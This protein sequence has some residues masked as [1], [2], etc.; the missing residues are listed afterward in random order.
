[1][2]VIAG[3]GTGKTTVLEH[4]IA[5]LISH[6]HAAPDEILA[7]TYTENAARNLHE[8]VATLLAREGIASA[9]F[10]AST[11]HAYCYGLLRKHGKAFQVVGREDLWVYLRRNIAELPLERFVKAANPG[12]FLDDLLSFYD[13]CR[14]ELVRAADYQA[15]VQRLRT[16]DLPLPRVGR[17]REFEE[18][19]R[20]EVIAYCE[21]IARVY[22]KVEEILA[23][24]NMG[25]WGDM[26][27]GALEV[28]T[29]NPAVLEQER[30]HAR[31]ILIDEF[32]DSNVAQIELAALLAEPGHNVFAV[33]D[34]DQ[35]IYR[36]RGATSGAFDEFA[37]RFPTLRRERLERNHRSSS[38]I[39][40]G[41]FAVIAKN[42]E[43]AGF[44]RAALR[45][46]RE[47][48]VVTQG[49][50]LEASPVAIVLASDPCAEAAEIAEAIRERH[51]HADGSRD[52]LRWREFAVLYRTH[53]HREQLTEEFSRRD[54]PFTV[55]GL[56]VLETRAI[57]DLLAAL[58]AVV[59]TRDAISLFRVAA[60]PQ[61]GI[62]PKALHHEMQKTGRETDLVAALEKLKEGRVVLDSIKSCRAWLAKSAGASDAILKVIEVFGL[63]VP[64]E[65][66][67]VL[68]NFVDAWEKKP[69]TESGSLSEF[70][71]YLDL[72]KE[73]RGTIP[74]QEPDDRLDAVRLLTAHAAKGLEWKQVHVI[75]LNAGSFP[76]HYQ[77]EVFAFPD[78]LRRSPHGAAETD[79]KLHMEEE[80]R[81]L[82]VAM[83]R[84]A[85]RLFLYARPGRG[86][87]K[88]PEGFLRELLR[89]KSVAPMIE[90]RGAQPYLTPEEEDVP[91]SSISA[92]LELP[93][94]RDLSGEPLSATAIENYNFCPLRFKIE[95][96]WRLPAEAHAAMQF[97]NVMH[98]VLKFYFDEV[99]SRGTCDIPEVL[100]RFCELMSRM[101][102]EDPLQRHLYVK[103][104]TVQLKKFIEAHRSGPPLLVAHTER[105]FKVEIGGVEVIGRMDRLD[106]LDSGPNR[107][108]IT[109]YKTGRPREQRDADQSLQLSI[110]AIAA[111]R[112]WSFQ[113]ERLV[114]HN[115][116]NNSRIE[117][118]RSADQLRA[119][120]EQVREVA[121]N[122]AAG[123]FDPN[124]GFHC[125][126][127]AYFSLCPETEQRLYSI[128]KSLQDVP[129]GAD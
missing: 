85:D 114:F 64:G 88:T 93:A 5:R 117:T 66:L 123:K 45:S 121:R 80:R 14:D 125:R 68:R 75:R 115:L 46:A 59:F 76:L 92:W 2:L 41:S 104:G 25:T 49:K 54:I 4:R 7:V 1:M 53:M 42:P 112:A 127:C 57:R 119:H 9:G 13:R 38:P 62:S 8:R 60:L 126:S 84:A 78:A 87:D 74:L 27:L 128:Q 109:D 37:R 94:Q 48:E 89:D 16:S 56:D 70:L 55:T 79:R 124:P 101:P 30:K 110:Y 118:S 105:T 24:K 31:F 22:L 51:A 28:L 44:A 26:I 33:G 35:A 103:H 83:T 102:F 98:S 106:A 91:S 36:F 43:V 72:F 12:K 19:S 61:F 47:E 18:L 23:A 96:D 69:I 77:E 116:E 32:Q 71:D 82:Y 6:Q 21:E 122:I 34:P 50:R 10:R 15:Y 107:I 73:A 108:A 3:A 81:L 17:T 29:S 111:M 20:D 95:H 63:V 40:Q 113:P 120:E 86:R 97:G 67:S 58:R 11:F 129:S 39:L 52:R 99:R 90:E 65:P 100:Q